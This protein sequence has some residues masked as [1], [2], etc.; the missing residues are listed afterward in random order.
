[1]TRRLTQLAKH[2]QGQQLSRIAS[3]QTNLAEQMQKR[4]NPCSRAKSPLNCLEGM[5]GPTSTHQSR[6]SRATLRNSH[7]GGLP[8]IQ[9]HSNRLLPR[10]DVRNTLQS[11][12][13]AK[14]PY[15]HPSLFHSNRMEKEG[16]CW[17]VDWLKGHVNVSNLQFSLVSNQDYRS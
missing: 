7:Y 10:H 12:A 4:R 17:R 1:V 15:V 6:L 8:N 5:G 3:Q 9:S 16:W 2:L 13:M 14:G 11:I